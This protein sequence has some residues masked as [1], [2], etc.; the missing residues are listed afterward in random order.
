MT[1]GHGFQSHSLASSLGVEVRIRRGI[2]SLPVP[3]SQGGNILGSGL[4]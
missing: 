2:K 3:Q 1:A 4:A